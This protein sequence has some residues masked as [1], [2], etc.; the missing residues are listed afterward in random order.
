LGGFLEERDA[1]KGNEGNEESDENERELEVELGVRDGGSGEE[2]DAHTDNTFPEEQL[3]CSSNQIADENEWWR[4]LAFSDSVPKCRQQP[5]IDDA[6]ENENEP[7]ALV[8]VAAGG[9][10]RW[11]GENRRR[12]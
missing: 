7:E 11:S 3:I 12:E 5:V 1:V 8:E 9:F 2:S 10:R 4:V 6:T